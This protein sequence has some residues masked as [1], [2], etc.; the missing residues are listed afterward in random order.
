MHP[1]GDSEESHEHLFIH[2][3]VTAKLWHSLIPRDNLAWVFP[4]S[5]AALAQ[6]WHNNFFSSSGNFI[7]DM[8][9]AVIVWVIWRERNCTTFE[10]D[11]TYK[12]YSD[13]IIDAKSILLSWAA[14]AGRRV[15]LNFANTLMNTW[16]TIFL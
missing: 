2:C 6:C 15:H 1:F 7:W 12:T 13:L 9:P 4:N 14:A 11:Y 5:F 3:K 16:Q 8:I 10:N